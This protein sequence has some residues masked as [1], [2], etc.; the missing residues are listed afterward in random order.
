MTTTVEAT[1]AEYLKLVVRRMYDAQKLRIQSDLR[2]QRLVRDGIILKE[3]AESAFKAALA[4][5]KS[6]EKEYEKI[7]A[8]EIKKIP[9]AGHWLLRVRGIGPRLS[10]L[11]IANIGTVARFETVGHLWAYAGLHVLDTGPCPSCSPAISENPNR[12]ASSQSPVENQGTHADSQYVVE[13]PEADASSPKTAEN[14]NLGADSLITRENQ[15]TVASPSTRE[16]HDT[17]ASSPHT[18]E[19]QIRTAS[20]PKLNENPSLVASSPTESE[21]QKTGADSR[22]DVEN[23]AALASQGD[24]ENPKSSASSQG[25]PENLTSRASQSQAENQSTCAVCG[26]AGFIGKAPRRTLGQKS[27]WNSELKTTAWKAG[28]CF[29]KAG[30]PYKDL[31][32]EYK[33]RL[34]TRVLRSGQ[35]IWGTDEDGKTSVI[36]A[37][38]ALQG[39]EIPKPKKIEWSLGRLDRMSQRRM[40][41][42]FLSHLYEV[43]RRLEGL[44]IVMPFIL[45][46]KASH[47]HYL[48]PW[49]FVEPAKE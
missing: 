4:L 2:L 9:I 20:S 17:C 21:N 27:N 36:F 32:D 14:Q 22:D 40:V 25:R 31:Y 48:D 24:R 15:T 33:K 29:I 8:R 13:N 3:D 18:C 38:K 6:T 12:R 37:P 49:D 41:K 11:L 45:A 47:T 39:K 35:P 46:T 44:P 34:V 7:I 16:N 5:E 42:I 19:N 10:G 23:P 26:G 28:G 30:G 43:W 1:S